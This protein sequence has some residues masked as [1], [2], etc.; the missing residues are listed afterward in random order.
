MSYNSSTEVPE[1]S[2]DGSFTVGNGRDFMYTKMEGIVVQPD[3][4]GENTMLVSLPRPFTRMGARVVTTVQTKNGT[5]PVPVTSLKANWIRIKGLAETLTYKLGNTAWEPASGYNSSFTFDKFTRETVSK[6][7]ISEA[8]V[9]LPVDGSQMLDFE[10]NLTVRYN[11]GADSYTGS[12]PASIQKVLLPGMTYQFDFS[13][14]FYGVLK[15]SDLTLAVKEYDTVD[16]SSD[17][18]GG[19]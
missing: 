15:P 2:T 14:T 9:V 10:V 16:L 6:P 19:D 18:L 3:K 11:E 8:Q 1:L 4:T 13:L 17:G 12:F 7:W 5:Q